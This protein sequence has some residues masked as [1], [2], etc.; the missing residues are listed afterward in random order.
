MFILHRVINNRMIHRLR[1][2]RILLLMLLPSQWTCAVAT[3]AGN[4]PRI[5]FVILI[6]SIGVRSV[7]TQTVKGQR[8]LLSAAVLTGD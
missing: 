4:A 8:S 3:A 7:S 6:I 5:L 2:M 1:V